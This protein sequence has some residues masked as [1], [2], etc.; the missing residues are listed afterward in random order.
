MAHSFTTFTGGSV[1]PWRVMSIRTARGESLPNV[2]RI[3]I[4]QT[5]QI[6]ERTASWQLTGVASYVRYVGKAEEAALSARHIGLGR[7]EATRAALIPILKSPAWWGLTQEERRAIFETR[8]RH[9]AESLKFLPA[10]QRQLYH[11][12]DL[13]GAFDFLTWFEFAPA[14]ADRFEELVGYLRQ[15]EE[16]NYIEREVDLRL[17]REP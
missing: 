12:H 13:G 9:I 6:P 8:S 17:S 11:C 10:V 1:G 7:P 16:W 5:P 15:T 2:A 3:A 4:A 14:D